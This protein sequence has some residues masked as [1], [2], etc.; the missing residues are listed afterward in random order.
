MLGIYL[1]VC[2]DVVAEFCCRSPVLWGSMKYLHDKIHKDSS[3]KVRISKDLY[4][5]IDRTTH[6][7]AAPELPDFA[8]A[9]KPEDYRLPRTDAASVND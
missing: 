9:L 4:S 3:C 5:N 6:E 2:F 8:V 7:T 1:Y